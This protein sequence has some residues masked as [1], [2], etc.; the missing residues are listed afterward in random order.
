MIPKGMRPFDGVYAANLCPFTPTYEVDEAELARHVRW[1]TGTPGIT[2]VLCNGHGGEVTMLRRGER[3]RVVEVVASA[4]G[5]RAVVVS[6]IA[7]EGTLEAVEHARDARQA[8]ADVLLIFPPYAWVLSQDGEVAVAH[9]RRIAVA[10][11][12]PL[13]AFQYSVHAG[14]APYPPSVLRALVSLPAVVGV[15]E[16]SWETAAYERN[17]RLI[18]K[19][20]PRVAVMASGDEHLLTTFILGTDGSMVSLASLMPRQIVGLYEAVRAG[21]WKQAYALHQEVQPVATAIY[22]TPPSGHAIPRL[23]ACLAMTGTL[24]HD[25][26][27][28][29]LRP[30]D[31]AERAMLRRALKEARLL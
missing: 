28:P 4:I 26:V 9:H 18:R 8:G 1:I 16:G 13:L 27:R 17:L 12:L 3:R 22:G 24:T 10:A 31:R 21:D 30:P 14:E 23:K 5:D 11:R 2:G 6:G 29:P 19:A 20:A 15:K 7:C 25:T